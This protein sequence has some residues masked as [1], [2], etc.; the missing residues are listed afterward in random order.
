MTYWEK[1]KSEGAEGK[2]KKCEGKREKGKGEN[3]IKNGVK[4]LNIASF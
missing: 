2:K 1:I 3:C 4:W